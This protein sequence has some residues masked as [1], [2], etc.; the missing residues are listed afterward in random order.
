MASAP[1]SYTIPPATIS[2]GGKTYQSN[3]VT[4]AVDDSQSD[5]LPADMLDKGVL[6][7]QVSDQNLFRQLQGRLFLLP[8]ASK[9]DPYEGEPC[10]VSYEVY[11]DIEPSQQWL[12]EWIQP[13]LMRPAG[14]DFD[15]IETY[16]IV[17]PQGTKDDSPPSRIVNHDNRAFHVVTVYEAICVPKRAGTLRLGPYHV[18]VVLPLRGYGQR[19]GF[20]FDNDYPRATLPTSPLTFQ[21]K[22]LP[23]QGRPADFDNIIG[24]YN[25]SAKLDRESMTDAEVATLSVRFQGHG[26][27]ESIGAPRLPDMPDFEVT[28]DEQSLETPDGRPGILGSKVQ[29]YVLR[30]KRPGTLTVPPIE[31]VIFNPAKRA[32]ERLRS[33]PISVEV[34]SENLPPLLIAGP[35]ES[36]QAMPG[37]GVRNLADRLAYIRTQGFIGG[38]SALPLH[39][40]PWFLALQLAPLAFLAGAFAWSRRRQALARDSSRLRSRMARGAAG[41]RLREAS[42]LCREGQADQFYAELSAALRGFFGDKLNRPAAGLLIEQIAGA[43]RERS[44]GEAEIAAAQALLERCDNAR[45][46]PGSSGLSAMSDSLNEAERLIN[47]LARTI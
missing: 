16:N 26:Y 47:E 14:D 40:D 30:P 7:A 28:P 19:L 32:Y 25:L 4:V 46:A 5:A 11:S 22:P 3:P 9:L 35:S 18:N 2:I 13:L 6:P 29:K 27:L 10:T 43:L 17:T 31:A 24:D 12:S 1:G 45:F 15:F 36:P 8:S 42:K 38:A 44:V 23:A 41:R 34:T 33:D 20:F 21:V 37:E 39:R